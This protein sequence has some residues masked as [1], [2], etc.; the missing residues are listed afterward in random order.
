MSNRIQE[1]RGFYKIYTDSDDVGSE[2][3]EQ[4]PEII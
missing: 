3:Q 2:M 1:T 4:N